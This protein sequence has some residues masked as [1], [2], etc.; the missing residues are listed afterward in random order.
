LSIGGQIYL[1]AQSRTFAGEPVGDSV[2][3]FPT[4]VDLYFDARPND[5]VRGYVLGRMT[6]DP[7]IS[8]NR[9]QLSATEAA[10]GSASLTSLFGTPNIGPQV[11]LDQLW[12]RFDIDHTLFVTAGKQ[13]VRWGTGHVWSPTDYLH[14][15]KRN[16]LEV[17]DART[18]T[19]MLKLH[20]PIE[21]KA[22][23]FYAYGVAEGPEGVPTLAQLGAAVRAEVVF[24]ASEIGLGAF[25][26]KGADPKFA[27]DLSAGLGDFDLFLEVAL[28]NRDEVD[29][30]RYAPNARLP[31][32][33]DR[34]SWQTDAE[35]QQAV[36]LDIADARFP[37]F[38]AEGYRPQTVVGVSY[39]LK[40]H[41]ND[42]LM[43][44]AEYFYN[45]FGYT[46]S[47]VYPGLLAPRAV[48]LR[49]PAT[50]FYLGKHYAALV[51]TAPS[52]FSLDLHSFTLS[53]LGNLS[54]RSFITQLS[55][56]MVVLTH[57][58]F[59]AFVAAHYGRPSG[60]FRLRVQFEGVQVIPAGLFDVG[61]AL[62][63]AI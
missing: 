34:E 52:P 48:P 6:Y 10:G 58:R 7:T 46:D 37:R 18:G 20:L 60:E 53:T 55:Y 40:Y 50:Y 39:S 63:L 43:V 28:R 35:Y 21:S 30:V 25:G 8:A 9:P 38:R 12:L 2:F 4:L 33:P 59:E 29:R 42:V 57:L 45:P 51:L 17:F 16:P 19:T 1:R 44:S 49:D 23:N 15:Q 11:R 22:W 62:R 41:E 31:E 61:V 36:A 56:S 47:S 13:H 24:G 14:V 32:P 3:N 26:Q 5:R 27:A 54:D